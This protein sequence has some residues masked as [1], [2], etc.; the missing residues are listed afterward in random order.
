MISK[1]AISAIL[2]IFT[3]IPSYARQIRVALFRGLPQII[4]VRSC[5]MRTSEG[6]QSTISTKPVDITNVSGMLKI[7]SRKP[8]NSIQLYPNKPDTTTAIQDNHSSQYRRYRGWIEIRP[9]SG[10]LLVIN[11]ID[12][13]DYLRG[14]VPGEMP[15]GWPFQA[16]A[17]QA[18]VARSYAFAS[19]GRHTSEGY[20][21]C[22]LT[23]CQIYHGVSY[24]RPETDNA[25]RATSGLVLV[26]QGN[27]VPA[28]YHSTCGGMTTDGLYDGHRREP[29]LQPVSDMKSSK[30][31]CAAS[32]H[33]RWKSV[34]SLESIVETLRMD[35][36]DAPSHSSDMRILSTDSSGR[37]ALIRLTGETRNDV[38]G[39]D[40]M[41]SA[42]RHLGWQTIKST[43]FTIRKSGSKM[44]FEGKGLGHGMGMCQWGARGMAEQ[45]HSFQEIL[46]HYFPKCRLIKL[47]ANR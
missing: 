26:Y 25:V 7:G 42:G 33:F 40:V 16:Y 5:T 24:E 9:R 2:L 20:D 22:S 19:I 35:K 30:A 43:K 47:R 41:M 28:P 34:T 11:H 14:V 44:V 46:R 23:H 10:R 32:P 36:V 27:P 17:S 1:I 6:T 15:Q 8:A 39:Y 13:E 4:S 12:I 29:F 31:Y 21:L 45:G 18:I 37:A 38:S 3:I